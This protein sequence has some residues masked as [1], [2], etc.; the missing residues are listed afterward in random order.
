MSSKSEMGKP[1]SGEGVMPDAAQG[2]VSHSGSEHQH[3]QKMLHWRGATAAF[4]N[5]AGPV[6][7]VATGLLDGK[8]LRF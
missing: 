7:L 5:F 6:D 3:F 8:D 2:N 4:R 1:A